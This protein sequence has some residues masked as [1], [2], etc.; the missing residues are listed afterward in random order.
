[1]AP[2]TKAPEQMEN[3]PRSPVVG[4][5]QDAEESLGNLGAA[6]VLPAGDD[7]HVGRGHPGQVVPDLELHAALR[8]HRAPRQSTHLESVP[9]NA[10]L[11]AIPP[12]ISTAVPN[13]K[14]ERSS[15]AR[16]ATR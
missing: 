2:S 1:M 4:F 16:S 6:L 5:V 12:N 8:A 7:H 15:Y 13:S 10:E 11:R 3:Q 9:G 14:V